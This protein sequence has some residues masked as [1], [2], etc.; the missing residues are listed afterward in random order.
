MSQDPNRFLQFKI[1]ASLLDQIVSLQSCLSVFDLY[2]F[3]FFFLNQYFL[4]SLF[5]VRIIQLKSSGLRVGWSCYLKQAPRLESGIWDIKPPTAT[6]VLL[7]VSLSRSVWLHGGDSVR[8]W[9]FCR[10]LVQMEKESRSHHSP[11]DC[12]CLQKDSNCCCSN[13]V[14]TLFRA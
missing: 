13:S 11:C 4:S 12:I 9:A 6:I 5:H 2:T 1:Y 8:T 10:V 14:I 3:F 7:N